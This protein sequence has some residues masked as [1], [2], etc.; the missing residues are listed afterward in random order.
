M[1]ECYKQA[2]RNM[3]NW[4]ELN[5]TLHHLAVV[6]VIINIINLYIMELLKTPPPLPPPLRVRD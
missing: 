6:L 1:L 4:T 5:C 2:P 3:M